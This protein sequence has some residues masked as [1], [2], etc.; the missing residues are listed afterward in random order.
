MVPIV[1]YQAEQ[2]LCGQIAVM[3]FRRWVRDEIPESLPSDE[4]TA[5]ETSSHTAVPEDVVY[6][7]PEE[8]IQKER[9]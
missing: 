5:T 3:L 4:E 7:V 8:T 1:L 2:I 9:K 6:V